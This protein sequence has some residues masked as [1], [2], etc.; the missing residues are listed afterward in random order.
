MPISFKAKLAAF[1]NSISPTITK[2]AVRKSRPKTSIVSEN[3]SQ[4]IDKDL[5]E[6]LKKDVKDPAMIE[7]YKKRFEE[8]SNDLAVI[9][10]REISEFRNDIFPCKASVKTG[11][12]LVTL[13]K[14]LDSTMIIDTS[15]RAAFV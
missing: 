15:K 12:A 14:E 7:E 4:S 3:A 6:Y 2:P 13:L 5:P 10:A 9:S 11:I 1:A 8:Y